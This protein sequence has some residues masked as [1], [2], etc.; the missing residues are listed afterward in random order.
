MRYGIACAAFVAAVVLVAALLMERASW[1]GVA[2]AAAVALPVQIVLF[3]VMSRSPLGTNRFLAA[4]VGGMLVRMVIVGLVAWVLYRDPGLPEAPTLLGLVAF[5]FVM[6]LME[7]L[8]L[9]LRV[10][11]GASALRRE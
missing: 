9:G 10:S 1:M 6:V 4:W 8:F 7:P 11:R 2:S 3:A 5:F